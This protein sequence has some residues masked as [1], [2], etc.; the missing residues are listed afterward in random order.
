V[1]IIPKRQV[2]MIKAFIKDII[3]NMGNLQQGLLMQQ[4][5]Q[6]L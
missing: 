1:L 3:I 6:Q 5:Q 4:Q 2:A